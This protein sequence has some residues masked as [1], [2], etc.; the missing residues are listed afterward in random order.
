MHQNRAGWWVHSLEVGIRD[1]SPGEYPECP[2]VSTVM[3]LSRLHWR[4]I[5]RGGAMRKQ[6]R[7]HKRTRVDVRNSTVENHMRRNGMTL[8]DRSQ[9]EPRETESV[10]E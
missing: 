3:L 10:G 6:L 5:S 2:G 1:E 4:G 8:W 9:V 7:K